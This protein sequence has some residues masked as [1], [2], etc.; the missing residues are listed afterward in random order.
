MHRL[1]IAQVVMARAKKS[2]DENKTASGFGTRAA[3]GTRHAVRLTDYRSVWARRDR[4]LHR[5]IITDLGG[6]DRLSELELQIVRR[7]VGLCL[8]CE[9][10]EAQLANGG[11]VDIVKAVSAIDGAM[12]ALKLFGSIY[13]L[14]GSDSAS[15]SDRNIAQHVRFQFDLG[16]TIFE[17]IA[18]ADE[19]DEPSVFH[20]GKVP[21]T[22]DGHDFRHLRNTVIRRAGDDCSRHQFGDL[23]RMKMPRMGCERIGQIA[24]RNDAIDRMPV[25]A[26]D[27][28]THARLL[29]ALRQCFDGFARPDGHHGSRAFGF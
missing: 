6:I 8:W 27:H 19:A 29:K 16:Q 24:L 28:R 21:D 14:R 3:K 4:E 9:Q 11:K 20:H 2:Q 10:Y 26:D 13:L 15:T 25:L 1:D 17:N 23:Q 12:L 5:A 18:N 22:A 7:A